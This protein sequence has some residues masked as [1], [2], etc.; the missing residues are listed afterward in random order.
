M[1]CLLQLLHL[2]EFEFHRGGTAEDRHEDL[3]RA[4]LVVDVLDDAV[5]LKNG[6]SMIRT[7][8]PFSNECLG[9]G[10]SEVVSIWVTI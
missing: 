10:F 6:P 4:A 2:E 9:L 1:R 8:S 5:E 7:A 3:Q